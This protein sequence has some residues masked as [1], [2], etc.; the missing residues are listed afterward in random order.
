MQ[1][2]KVFATVIEKYYVFLCN[3]GKVLRMQFRGI[4]IQRTILKFR[5]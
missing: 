5:T 4:I 2:I 3:L 1:C